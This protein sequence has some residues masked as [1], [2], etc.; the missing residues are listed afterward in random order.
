MKALGMSIEND[1]QVTGRYYWHCLS[2]LIPSNIY[3]Y[4]KCRH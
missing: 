1:R 3:R 4:M 2:P